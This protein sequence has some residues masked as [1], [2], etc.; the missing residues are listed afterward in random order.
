MTQSAAVTK[1]SIGKRIRTCTLAKSLALSIITCEDVSAISSQSPGS[2][3]CRAVPR[4]IPLDSKS[5]A[6]FDKAQTATTSFQLSI[7]A[8]NLA[9][10]KH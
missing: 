6:L 1:W 10:Q 9:E 8:G 4:H 5:L 3:P 2:K 7:T